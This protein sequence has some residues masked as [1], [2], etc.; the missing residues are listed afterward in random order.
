MWGRSSGGTQS[1]SDDEVGPLVSLTYSDS[2]HGLD[3]ISSFVNNVFVISIF[4]GLTLELFDD[5][6]CL[7]CELRTCMACSAHAACVHVHRACL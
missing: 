6:N 5:P 3:V 4:V 2:V 7:Q 1:K